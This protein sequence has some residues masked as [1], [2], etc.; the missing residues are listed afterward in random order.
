MQKPITLKEL[1][2]LER[3]L[4]ELRC[5]GQLPVLADIETINDAI[6]VVQ[7]LNSQVNVGR[8]RKE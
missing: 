7:T 2:D 1:E 3:R 5:N 8:A 6:L 4:L